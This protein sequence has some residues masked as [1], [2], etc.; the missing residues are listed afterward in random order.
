MIQ[1]MENTSA[2]NIIFLL[3]LAGEFPMSG[4]DI[5]GNRKMLLRRIDDM[6]Q[7]Q[8]YKNPDTG[9]EIKSLTVL[10]KCGKGEM[11]RL[12]LS[13][14]AYPILEWIGMKD[15]YDQRYGKMPMRGNESHVERNCRVAEVMAMMM[16]AGLNPEL[17]LVQNKKLYPG[18]IDIKTTLQN[19][20]G[21][22]SEVGKQKVG[23]TRVIGAFAT[24]NMF[25]PIYNTR[26]KRMVWKGN[27][28]SKLKNSCSTFAKRYC[29]TDEIEQVILF[30][31]SYQVGV[32]MVN[33]K[34]FVAVEDRRKT[35]PT[36]CFGNLY[37]KITFVPLD[38]F[39]VR[40]LRLLLCDNYVE[41]AT[42]LVFPQYQKNQRMD[43][44][45]YDGYVDGEYI[46]LFFDSELNRLTRFYNEMLRRTSDT[47]RII[48]YR[49]Q[50]DFLRQLFSGTNIRVKFSTVEIDEIEAKIL[51]T[52][53]GVTN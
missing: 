32:E 27:A 30:G 22:S 31:S 18:Y 37:N 17:N 12:R 44:F 50:L 35:T 2:Y 28:E 52:N 25:V 3:A 43:V 15:Y 38:Q 20:I 7:P 14:R 29:G 8:D 10:L 33:N 51:N 6:L 16:M 42:R 21:S 47:A 39:G 45:E 11:K 49:E 19:N 41:R 9:Q 1:V 36:T 23:F 34:E 46:L 13:K 24:G 40:L 4:L 48:C 53:G 5:I 26:N